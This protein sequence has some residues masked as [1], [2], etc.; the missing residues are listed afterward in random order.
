MNGGRAMDQKR[1]QEIWP[2]R[3]GQSAG[4]A[5]RAVAEAARGPMIDIA[6]CDIDVPLSDLGVQ[7]SQALADWFAAMPDHARL[8]LNV[9]LHSPYLRA[10]ETA[11]IAL[12]AI[13]PACMADFARWTCRSHPQIA[14]LS[15]PPPCAPGR[16]PCRRATAT[17]N[18]AATC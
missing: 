4:N 16:C 13:D 18:S 12:Q 7:Q 2:V 10:A 15:T 5:A 17:R 1:P 9:V 3:H 11:R 8:R 6:E 14:S